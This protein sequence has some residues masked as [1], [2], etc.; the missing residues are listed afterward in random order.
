MKFSFIVFFSFSFIILFSQKN[1]IKINAFLDV[2]KQLITIQQDIIFYNKSKDTLQTIYLHNWMNSYKGIKTPLS[3]RL[4]EDYNKDLYFAKEKNKGFSKI[5]TLFNTDKKIPLQF[6]ESISD[7]VKVSL[8]NKLAPNSFVKITVNYIVKVPHDKFTQ[9]GRHKNTYN[10]RFWYLIPAVYEKEKWAL[11]SN[12][13]MD[14]LYAS[15]CDYNINF[16]IPKTHTLFTD[17]NSKFNVNNAF[18]KYELT[19]KN[20]V[21][22]E[23]NISK[24]NDFLL[25]KTK[26]TQVISD[27]ET[28]RLKASN[29]LSIT[30]RQLQFIEDLLGV[31]Y[32]H[33]TMLL[34]KI[35][36]YKNPVY[37]FN[38][39]PKF[40]NPFKPV[41]EYDI[42]SFKILTEKYINNTLI[43]NRR[44]DTW[45]ND[46]LQAYLMMAYVKKYY[47]EVN[48]IGNISKI[49]G[50]RTYQ[51]AS[52]NYNKKYSF[53]HQFAMR[54]NL[55][56]ALTKNADSLSAFSRKIVN[57]YKAGLGLNYL[58]SFLNNSILKESL[59]QFYKENRLKK[60]SSKAFEKIIKTKTDKNLAWF[61]NGYLQTNKKMDYTIKKIKID[62]DSLKVNIENIRNFTAPIAIYG[63]SD[64]KIKYKKWITNISKDSIVTI[65]NGDF[66]SVSLNYESIYPEFNLNN[67]WKTIKP[68]IFNRPLKIRF[69]KDIDD[70][71]YNQLFYNI[72]YDY[73]YYDGIIAGLNI[74]NKTL[75]HKKW[76]FKIKPKYGFASKKLTGNA[77]FLYTNYFEKS[78]FNKLR[79]GINA[80]TSHYAPDLS[81]QRLS[82]FFSLDYKRKSLRD[83]GGENISARYILINKEIATNAIEQEA[84]SYAVFNA[85]YG[86]YKPDILK[87]IYYNFDFQ[88]A[89][90]FSKLNFEFQYRKLSKSNRQ[91]DFRFYAG[92][93]LH[94]NTVSNFFDY[95]LNRPSDYMFDYSY[96][97]RSEE[98]GFLSQQI[99]IA[100]G[101]FKSVFN[102]NTANQWMATTNASVGVWRWIEL[103]GD[104]GLY[105]N[106]YNNPV[107]KY[108]S[109]IRL[110]FVNRF[111]EVY[112]P[113]QSSNGFEPNQPRYQ[114]KIRFVATLSFGKIFNF[115]KRGFY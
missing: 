87:D 17:L 59:Q 78:K 41:F 94:N 8:Q 68:R 84:D 52:L 21:D 62:G 85:R 13:N 32:P 1:S 81:Y 9:Y 19:G 115:V 76:L 24:K 22:I 108:D 114:E 95:S 20:R 36:Y 65:P 7:I 15:P 91:Y 30:E 6:D 66:K 109:G 10:L 112:F 90:N 3:K 104:V 107:F 102:E 49:W 40:L 16:S 77:S 60:T 98:T 54:K 48:A 18:K 39:L 113:I 86:F 111:F 61:F 33:E 89:K 50:V 79:V 73:N 5:L 44:N 29:I 27:L 42:K 64:K 34:N 83:V 45:L 11:M 106:R 99:I 101:G 97:G 88:L 47:P 63:I 38:Q 2:E 51:I 105:K 75:L 12:Y 82:P 110:N 23:L 69:M 67:N 96:F 46:G 53:V 74:S 56:Q 92:R 37:G 35:S 72:E 31:K 58:D 100:E 43:T 70:P 28:H 80:S 71:Y 26:N 55:D 4:L 14:D 103:Y 57:K 25:T 93:F